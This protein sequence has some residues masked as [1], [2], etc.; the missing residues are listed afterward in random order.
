MQSL[1]W[2]DL[3]YILAVGRTASLAG[4]ARLLAVDPTT[5]A[6]RLGTVERAL[7]ARLFERAADGAWHPTEAGERALR[8]AESAEAAIG[9]LTATVAGT[10]A[11]GAVR[12]T[13]VPLLAGRVLAP[14]SPG[15]AARYPDIQLELVSDPRDLSLTRREADIALRLA[16]PGADAGAA[17]L[18]RR[19]GTL[20]YGV[21]AARS[22]ADAPAALP[23]VTYEV[24]MARLPQAVWVAEAARQGD[25]IAPVS[26]NDADALM[27]AVEA[28]LGRALL[29]RLV[30][31][32][33]P[34]LCLLEEPRPL[35]HRDVWL[36]IHPEL[37][38]LARIA[39]VADWIESL[40]G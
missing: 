7:N 22:A 6:R 32:R 17:I 13:A 25:P 28:G 29:P 11:A 36:L 33:R 38:P 21:Y 8:H 12:V 20:V 40:L 15:F 35:P 19:V 5:V 37:R 39:A 18:A 16:R 24:G 26:F 1:N 27:A 9:G 23:W 30:A 4:A 31:D 34:D 3:R 10:T 14:A 2:N